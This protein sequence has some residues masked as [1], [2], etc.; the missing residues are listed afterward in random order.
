MPN[1]REFFV[2]GVK[3]HDYR[4]I[5]NDVS[6]GNTLQLIPD[7]TN[8]FDPN[9]VQIYFDNGDKAAFIGF[10]PKKF[11]S[12]IS[13]LLEVGIDLE[14]TLTGFAKDAKTWEIFKVEI[15]EVEEDV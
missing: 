2:A 8:K 9:A 10:V 11:S 7:P 5:L 14:C 1:K 4:S 12:E 6:E 3:F 13:A 15:K